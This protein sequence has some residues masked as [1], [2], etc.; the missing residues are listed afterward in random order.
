MKYYP[1][2]APLHWGFF[3]I[4]FY[5][6]FGPQAIT[7]SQ[8]KVVNNFNLIYYYLNSLQTQSYFHFSP[9]SYTSV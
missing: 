5:Q 4:Y 1:L 8:E 9:A 2:C 7:D 3:P 6:P